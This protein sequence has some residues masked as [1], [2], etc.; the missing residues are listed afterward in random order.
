M[1]TA[2][3][4]SG[5]H[6]NVERISVLVSSS[7]VHAET[8]VWTCYYNWSLRAGLDGSFP[9]VTTGWRSDQPVQRR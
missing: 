1:A 6:D 8:I 7:W 5:C 4:S 9:I 2:L 3:G